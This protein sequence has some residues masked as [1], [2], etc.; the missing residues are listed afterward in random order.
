MG[1]PQGIG[2]DDLLYEPWPL[3]VWLRTP[4]YPLDHMSANQDGVTYCGRTIWPPDDW[5]VENHAKLGMA[6]EYW[7]A[8]S[9]RKNSKCRVCLNSMNSHKVRQRD[10]TRGYWESPKPT[11]DTGEPTISL[12]ALKRLL[13]EGLL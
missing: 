11:G 10:D 5:W 12:D 3:F 6:P 2:Q 7:V 9:R 1:L 4:L 8:E 13:K